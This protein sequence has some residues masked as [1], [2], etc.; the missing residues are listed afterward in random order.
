M[1]RVPESTIAAVLGTSDLRGIR[2][3]INEVSDFDRK[4][5]LDWGYHQLLKA[6]ED[7]R[8]QVSS[9]RRNKEKLLYQEDSSL[10]Y[11]W[12]A[13]NATP[14]NPNSVQNF[15]DSYGERCSTRPDFQTHTTQSNWF[16]QESLSED[17]KEFIDHALVDVEFIEGTITTR[18]SLSA[19]LKTA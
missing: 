10:A 2:H 19:R 5:K 7:M 8:K 1:S 6:E 9:T 17:T 4:E 12:I 13:S 16:L 18:G 3:F 14:E 15:V 11:K